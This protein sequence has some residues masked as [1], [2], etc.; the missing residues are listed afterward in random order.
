VSLV[1]AQAVADYRGKDLRN[2]M[3]FKSGVK[4]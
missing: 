2:K 3:G 1:Q 4:D